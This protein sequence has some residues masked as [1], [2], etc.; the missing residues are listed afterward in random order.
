VDQLREKL[1]QTS[2]ELMKSQLGNERE[3]ALTNQ[4]I[5]FQE[6]K[7]QELL[8]ALTDSNQSYQEKLN[9]QK[10]EFGAEST[11]LITRIE[12]ERDKLSVKFEEKRRAFKDLERTTSI[13]IQSLE[14]EKAVLEE[15]IQSLESK[16]ENET[17]QV[18]A[19]VQEKSKYIAEYQANA[20]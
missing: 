2:D 12:E 1:G 17:S 16:V 18:R 6:K 15:K 11:Q 20:L 10:S 3:A 14:K 5:D 19:E 7:I 8:K 4:K 9:F 13:T